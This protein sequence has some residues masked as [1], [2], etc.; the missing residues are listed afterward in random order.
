MP[1]IDAGATLQVAITTFRISV[2]YAGP[3]D[4]DPFPCQMAVTITLQDGTGV[5]FTAGFE[6]ELQV[7]VIPPKADPS[8]SS[9]VVSIMNGSA[10]RIEVLFL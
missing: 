1:F 8:F 5:G 10:F 9:A 3:D 2:T 6:H 7:I 4:P